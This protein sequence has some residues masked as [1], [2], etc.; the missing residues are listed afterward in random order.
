MNYMA[1]PFMLLTVEKSILVW[2]R[3]G[4]YGHVMIGGAMVFFYAGGIKFLRGIQKQRAKRAGVST[5]GGASTPG[6]GANT[7]VSITKM[8][9]PLDDLAQQIEAKADFGTIRR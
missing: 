2:G 9:A 4:W 3:L 5:D 7:P 1:G 6:T 8:A